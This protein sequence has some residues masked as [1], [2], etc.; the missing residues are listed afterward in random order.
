VEE[1]EQYDRELQQ[2]IHPPIVHHFNESS[3]VEEPWTDIGPPISITKG[4][5]TVIEL[6][7]KISK[8]YSSSSAYTLSAKTIPLEKAVL[9]ISSLSNQN[10]PHWTMV[11]MMSRCAFF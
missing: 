9:I 6:K 4:P 1:K 5:P 7:K 3:T 11:P 8:F 10:D 2:P